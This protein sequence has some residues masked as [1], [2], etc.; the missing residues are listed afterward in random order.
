[1]K[2]LIIAHGRSGS[3][4]LNKSLGCVLKIIRYAEPF[5][6]RVWP[7]TPIIDFSN[8]CIVKTL[9]GQT[10][11]NENPI[12]FYIKFSNKFDIVIL[13]LRKNKKETYESAI[14]A[15]RTDIWNNK[16]RYNNLE[17]PFDMSFH[18]EHIENQ[19]NYINELSKQLNLPIT[20]YEDLYSDNIDIF[21]NTI[22]QIGLSEYTEQLFPHFDPKNRLRQFGKQTLI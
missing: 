1:M 5:N 13:L 17:V 15:H 8:D 19:H 16:Y 22:K 10:P 6:I 7:T 21:T 12:D 18:Y 20:Y 14:Q 4:N 3:S 9:V 2:I 11:N